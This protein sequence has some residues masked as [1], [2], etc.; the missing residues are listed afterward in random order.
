[1]ALQV[2]KKN[3]YIPSTPIP[4][5]PITPK[6]DLLYDKSTG[7]VVLKEST[8]LINPAIL[9]KNG[10]YFGDAFRIPELSTNGFSANTKKSIDIDKDIKSKIRAASITSKGVL[11]EFAK[12]QNQNNQPGSNNR[13]PETNPGIASAFPGG[14]IL[15]ASP[16][17]GYKELKNIK[18]VV[19]NEKEAFGGTTKYPRDL[20]IN[21]DTLV[22]T[23]F[24][25]KAP[26][27]ESFLT[28][29][30]PAEIYQKGLQRNSALLSDPIGSVILPIPS[31]VKDSNNVA[32]GPD[33]M[34][35]MTAAVT[36]KFMQSDI[37]ANAGAVF[38]ADLLKN[39]ASQIPGFGGLNNI[40]SDAL[41]NISTLAYAL[42]PGLLNNPNVRAALDSMMMGAGGFEV[43][44][45][46]ILAKGFGI[47]PNSNMELL[48]TGP[49]LRSFQFG[50]KMSPRNSLEAKDVRKIIRFFKQGMAPRKVNE[51]N[52]PAGNRS[53]F[54]STPNVFKLQYKTSNKTI[55]GLNK[56][57]ICA[58]TGF[59]VDYA[60]DGN[61]AS[62]EDPSSPGQPVSMSIGLSFQEIE[63]VY[64]NDYQENIT[65]GLGKDLDVIQ[66]DDVGY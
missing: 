28:S 55:K 47:V 13:F 65:S 56:F 18:F 42:G 44:P 51:G 2:L 8:N 62:Y 1:M 9:Y 15:S 12:L 24:N 60:P 64:A 22:I 17:E 36:A 61:W 52:S 34:N 50:Y 20:D 41:R 29:G 25:Y 54:L 11:P 3:Y 63:P 10:T 46:T 38:G 58:L 7:E 33:N 14:S 16:G 40:P 37:F 43:P 35:D 49:T 32:W 5:A 4:G 19:N 31:G 59:A 39:V 57:K 45:E 48:F 23:Q 6:F 66:L 21:Q 53:L 30:N 26:S 27:G